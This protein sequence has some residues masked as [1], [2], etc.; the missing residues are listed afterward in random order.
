MEFNF[1]Q[2]GGGSSLFMLYKS[3]QTVVEKRP[4]D[5]VTGEAKNTLS[6]DNFLREKIDC[7]TMVGLI[8]SNESIVYISVSLLSLLLL[9][10]LF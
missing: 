8:D 5:E 6:E 7:L 1:V 10:S 3:T 4:V 2:E 9:V